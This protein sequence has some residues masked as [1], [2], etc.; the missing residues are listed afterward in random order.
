[1]RM[2]KRSK[3]DLFLMGSLILQ[4]SLVCLVY[5]QDT[6]KP[7]HLSNMFTGSPLWV[8]NGEGTLT[9][10]K[11]KAPE[12]G[13]CVRV[14]TGPNLYGWGTQVGQAVA[15]GENGKTYTLAFRA[16]SAKGPVS[17]LLGVERAYEPFAKSVKSQEFILNDDAWSELHLTFKMEKDFLTYRQETPP[18]SLWWAYIACAQSSAEYIADDILRL[19]EGEYTPHTGTEASTVRLF[20]TGSTASESLA[21]ETVSKKTGWK[22]LKATE[23]ES[24]AQGDLCL[25]NDHMLLVVRQKS[26]GPEWYYPLGDQ[27]VK[28]PTLIPTGADGDRAKGTTA[29]QIIENT[30]DHIRIGVTSKTV[31]GRTISSRYLLGKNAPYVETQPGDGTEAIEVVV[32]SRHAVLPD[33]FAED[34]LV[35]PAACQSSRVRFPSE[36]MVLQFADGGNAIVMCAW[37][38]TEQTVSMTLDGEGAN[39]MFTS[40]GVGYEKKAG[41]S[42]WVAVLAAPQIWYRQN[43]SELHHAKDKQLEWKLPF[44]GVWRA[45][46]QRPDG[47]IDSWPMYIRNPQKESR[48]DVLDVHTFLGD[49]NNGRNTWGTWRGNYKW[50]AYTENY[51]AFLRVSRFE[52]LPDFKY[53]PDGYVLMYPFQRKPYTLHTAFTVFDILDLTLSGFKDNLRVQ[54]VERDKH[55]STCGA[56]GIV[57]AIFDEKTEKAKKDMILTRLEDTDQFVIVIRS[58]IDEYMAWLKD[59]KAACASAKK[60][61]P[62]LVGLV[63]ETEKELAKFN[64][65]WKHRDLTD[66]TPDAVKVLMNKVIALSDSDEPNKSDTV[67]QLGREIRTIGGNQDEA[68]GE[69]RVIVKEIRQR[70]GYAMVEAKDQKS[71]DFA[72]EIRD[73]TMK[74]LYCAFDHEGPDTN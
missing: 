27:M 25:F 1:M 42:V 34:L 18:A 11:E 52:S 5:G 28:G 21:P 19:Y 72:K 62:Q 10:E 63:A 54:P 14:K 55:Q 23:L 20:D 71:F 61:N 58:R 12:A 30:P 32:N 4:A 65:I 9:F 53:K 48:Y 24:V 39:R 36:N 13:H 41:A 33:I 2:L 45:D 8:L 44:I 74:M 67:N 66:G 59:A 60:A 22:E 17:V 69:F 68:M 47:L 15:A 31:S 43:I 56:T 29:V 26:Q 3:R 70:A 7:A 50:P 6:V 38:S 49:M 64:E 46:Y 40:T 16:K 51:A 37:P 35:D 57:E 73:S